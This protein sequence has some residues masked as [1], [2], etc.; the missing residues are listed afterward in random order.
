MREGVVDQRILAILVSNCGFLSIR[1]L[2]PSGTQSVHE[3]V[4][5]LKFCKQ[6]YS[7]IGWLYFHRPATFDRQRTLL[8]KFGSPYDCVKSSLSWRS[9]QRDL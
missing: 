9:T 8:A 6:I 5:S 7:K 2:I 4:D 1:F 3:F